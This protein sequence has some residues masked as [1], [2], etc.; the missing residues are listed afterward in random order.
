[1][2][3]L[4]TLVKLDVEGSELGVIRGA[5]E[6]L[7]RAE[8]AVIITEVNYETA[9]AF[10]YRPDELISALRRFRPYHLFRATPFGLEAEAR[11]YDAPHGSTWVFVPPGRTGALDR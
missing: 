2:P 11:P 8:H 10:G 5:R 3:M 6:T 7:G 4:P 9:A 1:M